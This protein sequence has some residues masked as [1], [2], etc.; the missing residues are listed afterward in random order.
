MIIAIDFDGTIVDHRFPD[1][2]NPVPGANHW[3]KTWKELGGTLF[4]WTMRSNEY[5]EAAIKYIEENKLEFDKYNH[6]EGQLSWTN[7]PKLYAHVYVDD[8]AFGCPLK[9]NP[10]MGGRPY[11]DWSIVGPAIAKQLEEENEK[12]SK[13]C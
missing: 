11:V 4:L 7:S 3:I 13:K 9:E 10:R 8:A 5:L 1:I 2:G 6:N 12:K